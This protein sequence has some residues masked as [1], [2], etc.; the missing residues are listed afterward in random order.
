MANHVQA[1]TS[2]VA[3]LRSQKSFLVI[4]RQLEL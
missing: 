1:N 4:Q 2:Q 3:Q